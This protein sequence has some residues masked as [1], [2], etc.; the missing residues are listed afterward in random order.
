MSRLL[1]FAKNDD[2]GFALA[3][4][5]AALW[6]QAEAF[7]SVTLDGDNFGGK[8]YRAKIKFRRP[9]GSLV[10]AEGTDDDKEEALRLAISE[11]VQ[12]SAA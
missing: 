12:L 2:S 7:G 3:T 8:L 4:S 11:A 1:N 9:S 5:F 6:D 10:F